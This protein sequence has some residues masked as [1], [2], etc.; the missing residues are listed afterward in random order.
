MKPGL[1]LVGQTF[2]SVLGMR[3]GAF[4][5]PEP[6]KTPWNSP[7]LAML[8]ARSAGA[9][10]PP[11]SRTTDRQECLLHQTGMPPHSRATDR[12]E[13]LPHRL[14]AMVVLAVLLA[15]PGRAADPVAAPPA[16]VRFSHLD[17]YLDVGEKPLAAY[18]FELTPTGGDVLLT[19]LEGG[20]HAAFRDAPYYDPAA[21]HQARSRVIVAAFN[22]GG[23]LP[24]GKTRVARLHL[25]VTGP[26]EPAWATKLQVAA[27]SDGKPI[28]AKLTLSAG[29]AATSQ[30]SGRLAAPEGAVP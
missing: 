14:L 25:Q 9:G 17:V 18:Q 12:R 22:T 21:L 8:V 30:N 28:D 5:P 11:H 3:A 27:S 16:A 23:D 1:H 10:M 6:A 7:M 26:A 15:T 19:G 13:R 29:S 20:E 4:V 24:R 2:L